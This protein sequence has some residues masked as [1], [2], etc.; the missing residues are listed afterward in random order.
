VIN[1]IIWIRDTGCYIGAMIRFLA[2][3]IWRAKTGQKCNF[4]AWLVM[5]NKVQTA[6]NWVKR[7][8]P[9]NHHCPF[10]LCL[11]ETTPYILS[12]CNFTV[13]VWNF[14]VQ[15]YNLPAFQILSAR[16]GPLYWFRYMLSSGT[17]KEK[18]K[19]SGKVE[20]YSPLG[21]RFGRNVIERFFITRR[22]PYC[23]FLH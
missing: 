8:C 21:G 10:W 12:L 5:H 2:V 13:A 18:C 1:I 11:N 22:P 17:D 20:P 7:N 15:R 6:D 4:F 16:G 14:T 19:K 9:C 3:G 23:K